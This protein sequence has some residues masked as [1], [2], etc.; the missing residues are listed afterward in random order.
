MRENR[1]LGSSTTLRASSTPRI[2]T[3]ADDI[4]SDKGGAQLARLWMPSK[5]GLPRRSGD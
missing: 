4:L 5:P 1:R 3:A 2:R